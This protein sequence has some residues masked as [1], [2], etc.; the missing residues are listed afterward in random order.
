M[1]FVIDASVAAAWFL[2]DE[3]SEAASVIARRL[4]TEQAYAPNLFQHEMRNLLVAACRRGRIP[5]D[6]LFL[7]LSKLDQ[8][9]VRDC[10]AGDAVR[11][12]QLALAHSL[13]AYDAT[14][15]A[16]AL[17]ESLPLA[18]FD[19]KLA[20]AAHLENVPTLGSLETP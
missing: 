5:E 20:A 7:Q 3:D 4:A 14:Y 9:P 8:L 12:A 19:R 15:L 13:T 1:A 11:I 17:R 2:P 10:G 6:L 16:L 18:T